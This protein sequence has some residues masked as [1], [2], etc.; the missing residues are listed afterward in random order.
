MVVR[1][2]RWL[3]SEEIRPAWN[4]LVS[5][6]VIKTVRSYFSAAS[7]HSGKG[8]TPWQITSAAMSN[9]MKRSKAA[10]RSASESVSR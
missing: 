4:S 10:S 8:C 1:G 2:A 7:R 5:S 6:G 3:R 9:C